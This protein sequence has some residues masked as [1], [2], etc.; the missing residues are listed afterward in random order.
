MFDLPCIFCSEHLRP[1]RCVNQVKFLQKLKSI[2]PFNAHVH[3]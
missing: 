2:Q 1:E 3:I